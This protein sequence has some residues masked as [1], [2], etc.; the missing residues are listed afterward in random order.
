MIKI[1]GKGEHTPPGKP[2]V[3]VDFDGVI[4][5]FISGWHGANVIGDPPVDEAIEWLNE[6]V[7]SDVFEVGIFSTRNFQEGGVE[8]MIDYL[9]ENGLTTDNLIKLSF[10]KEKAGVFLIIDDRAM[11]F[12]GIFPTQEDILNFKPWY[13]K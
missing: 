2:I 10:P 1:N 9:L 12:E 7:E 3:L 13:K 5:S 6:L 4:H 8:A 11:T